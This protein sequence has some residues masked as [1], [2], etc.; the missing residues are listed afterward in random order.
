MATKTPAMKDESP[1]DWMVA[2]ISAP[3]IIGITM[4]ECWASL[5]QSWLQTVFS[6]VSHHR[7]DHHADLALPDPIEA[8]GE[9]DLFA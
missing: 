3:F 1:K 6:P 4:L 9:H 5:S 2:M 8:D 7:H